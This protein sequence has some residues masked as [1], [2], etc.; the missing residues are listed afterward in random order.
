MDKRGF[1]LRLA[2]TI[3]LVLNLWGIK[4]PNIVMSRFGDS[5]MIILCEDAKRIAVEY[6]QLLQQI[7]SLLE[8]TSG[9]P[10]NGFGS[11]QRLD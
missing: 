7:T 2:L 1:T 6:T 8:E 10:A 9:K 4:A 5:A 3:C 11:D